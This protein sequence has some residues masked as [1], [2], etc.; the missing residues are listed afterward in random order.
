MK[1]KIKMSSLHRTLL[2]CFV[3]LLVGAGCSLITETKKVIENELN[4]EDMSAEEVKQHIEKYNDEYEIYGDFI[5]ENMYMLEFSMEEY[6]RGVTTFNN[7]SVPYAE[8]QEM[9]EKAINTVE[10]YV[11]DARNVEVPPL[12]H[13]IHRTYLKA[14]V[15]FE[16]AIFL[17][18]EDL[19]NDT[20]L[21]KIT[22]HFEKG[23]QYFER[24]DEEFNRLDSSVSQKLLSETNKTSHESD[25]AHELSNA[26]L[27]D[28]FPLKVGYRYNLSNTEGLGEAIEIIYQDGNRYLA[29]GDEGGMVAFYRVYEVSDDAISIILST[30]E[31]EEDYRMIRENISYGDYYFIKEINPNSSDISKIL[32]SP[33]EKGNT[34]GIATIHD[35]E[36][37]ITINNKTYETIVVRYNHGENDYTDY[38]YAKG[39]G[40]VRAAYMYSGRY[41]EPI[42]IDNYFE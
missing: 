38:Y 20:I 26:S 7:G 22:T 13:N 4:L 28:Y 8:D 17:K 32:F 6:M 23:I 14:L 41:E 29:Y 34:M 31:G 39:Y 27:L 11:R 18:D 36:T 24:T 35:V 37:H 21:E 30:Y 1:G 42:V 9:Y 19:T 16:E 15:E 25:A 3:F 12:A 33:V 2:L 5:E 40:V 10:K